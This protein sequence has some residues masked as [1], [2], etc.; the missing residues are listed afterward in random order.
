MIPGSPSESSEY[1]LTS[2]DDSDSEPDQPEPHVKEI[3]E[4]AETL[5][6]TVEELRGTVEKTAEET[7]NVIDAQNALASD[8]SGGAAPVPELTIAPSETV[9]SITEPS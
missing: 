1:Y 8:L 9:S 5:R 2:S 3:K 4:D 6:E 7:N